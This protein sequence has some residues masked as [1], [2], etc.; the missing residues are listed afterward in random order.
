VSSALPAPA[1]APCVEEGMLITMRHLPAEK[2][3]SPWLST[4]HSCLSG[5]AKVSSGS[6]ARSSWLATLKLPP[7]HWP[8]TKV[9]FSP[10]IWPL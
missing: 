5:V 3:H 10:W 6:S 9:S 1:K 4:F 2:F 8:V 7:C